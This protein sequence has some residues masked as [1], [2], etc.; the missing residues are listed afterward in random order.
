MPRIHQSS[1]RRD[2]SNDC[3]P[4]ESAIFDARQN[5]RADFDD[6]EI[7]GIGR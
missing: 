2:Q 5:A 6:G 4:I 7:F 3:G 1:Q